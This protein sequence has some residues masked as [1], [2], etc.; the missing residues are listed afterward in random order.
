LQPL[1]DFLAACTEREIILTF[2]DIEAIVDARLPASARLHA[3]YWTDQELRA[4][5]DWQALGWRPH[6]DVRRGHVRFSRDG[7]REIAEERS[8]APRHVRDQP[9]VDYLAAR[10]AREVVLTFAEI[11]AIIGRALPISAYV[12]APYWNG[13]H[14]AH[15]RALRALGWSGTIDRSNWTVRFTRDCRSA[16]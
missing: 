4:V 12:H 11:A 14:F 7:E 15:T 9:L 2:D 6:F 16:R 1:V 5:R 13:D 3:A 10:D 8:A